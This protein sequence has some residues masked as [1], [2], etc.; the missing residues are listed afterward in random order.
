MKLFGV[1]ETNKIPTRTGDVQEERAMF[2]E[3]IDKE[4]DS[5][6]SELEK[7]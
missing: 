2:A 4:V 3:A 7:Q 6:I 5:Y 1:L